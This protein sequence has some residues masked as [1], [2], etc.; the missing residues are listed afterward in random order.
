MFQSWGVMVGNVI[1]EEVKDWFT[2]NKL[3]EQTGQGQSSGGQ[4]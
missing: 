2:E 4:K 3:A 1:L